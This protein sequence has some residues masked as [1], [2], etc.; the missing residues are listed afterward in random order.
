M[1]TS[2]SPPLDVEDGLI[3]GAKLR[4]PLALTTSHINNKDDGLASI[5]HAT[6]DSQMIQSSGKKEEYHLEGPFKRPAAW[7]Q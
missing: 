1:P 4:S 5:C 3:V 2:S 7:L 6:V